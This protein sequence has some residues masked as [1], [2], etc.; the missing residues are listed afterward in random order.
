MARVIQDSE[1]EDDF[2]VTS[3]AAAPSPGHNVA[4]KDETAT[5]SK[6]T[7][8]TGKWSLLMSHGR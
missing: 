2:I 7:N 4:G 6:S 1:D 8:E 3:P 5:R